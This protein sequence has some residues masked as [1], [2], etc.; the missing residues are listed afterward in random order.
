MNDLH[1]IHKLTGAYATDALDDIERARFEQHLTDCRD[2]RGEVAELREAAARLSVISAT[3]PPESLRRSV[4]AEISQVRPLPPV[5]SASE[6]E[7]QDDP[8]QGGPVDDDV[9]D[10]D[11]PTP[12]TRGRNRRSR[13]RW[14]PMLVA[15]ALALVAGVSAW[16]PWAPSPVEQVIEAADA[17]KVLVE[18]D[19]VGRAEVVRS[20][21]EDR[22]VIITE[23]MPPAPEGR[24]YQLWFMSPEDGTTIPAGLMPEGEDNVVMLEGSAAE[25]TAVGITVEPEGGSEKPSTKPIAVFD[26]TQAT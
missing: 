13:G 5:V 6:V 21:S 8:P 10:A 3:T 15:A 24:V 22:A 18:L 14:I 19:R 17:E 11:G 9:H 23:D 16:Q 26:L 4:L 2:C 12:I 20:K 1:D 7:S 25:A